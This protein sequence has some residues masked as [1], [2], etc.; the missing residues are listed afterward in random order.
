[1]RRNEKRISLF[2]DDE[3][4]P[5]LEALFLDEVAHVPGTHAHAAVGLL[6]LDIGAFGAVDAI[7]AAESQAILGIM[8]ERIPAGY[9]TPVLICAFSLLWSHPVLIRGAPVRMPVDGNDGVFAL[10]CTVSFHSYCY[11]IDDCGICMVRAPAF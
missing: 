1:M 11:G 7:D 4:C 8:I 2:V 9:T 10:R 3:F 5:L 6:V